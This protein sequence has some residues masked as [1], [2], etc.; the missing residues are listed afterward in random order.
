LATALNANTGDGRS[1]VKFLQLSCLVDGIGIAT[2]AQH[3]NNRAL[4]VVDQYVFEQLP[5]ASFSRSS[6]RDSLTLNSVFPRL[7]EFP[8]LPGIWYPTCI[9]AF[10]RAVED[11]TATASGHRGAYV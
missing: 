4:G 8:E 7:L 5:T 3:A 9:L 10:M 11:N 1:I 6:R 2:D